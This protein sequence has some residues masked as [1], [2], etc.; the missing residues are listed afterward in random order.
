[1]RLTCG[2][3]ELLLQD[4]LDGYLLSTQREVLEEHVRSCAACATLLAGLA[5]IGDRLER[6]EPVEA[7]P[8]L[9]RSILCSLPAQAYRPQYVRQF[10]RYAAAPALVALLLV[11][12]LLLKGRSIDGAVGTRDVE[13]VFV[14]PTAASV[15]VVGDFNNWDPRRNQMARGASRD[16]W[17]TRLALPPGVYQYS[18]MVDGMVWERDPQ[19]KN[20]LADGFG[21]Q[22]SVFIVDG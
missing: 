4:Y 15:A 22:N 14:A 6:L 5:R 18:F 19:A 9:A 1:M 10:A 16:T 7:P 17:R 2:D 12:G 20:F 3:I 8:L 13:V 21:G 11:A